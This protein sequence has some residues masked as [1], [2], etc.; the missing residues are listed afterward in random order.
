MN[1]LLPLQ[2]GIFCEMDE[3]ASGHLSGKLRCNERA[4]ASQVEA[5]V[6]GVIPGKSTE[7]FLQRQQSLLRF[8]GGI[9]VGGLATAACLF[10]N[11]C[12]AHLGLSLNAISL[13]MVAGYV[14]SAL[15][16]VL[17]WPLFP[18]PGT[19]VFSSSFMKSA[20]QLP[21]CTGTRTGLMREGFAVFETGPVQSSYCEQADTVRCTVQAQSLMQLP[22]LSSALDREK[23]LLFTSLGGD[24]EQ[25]PKGL[26]PSSARAM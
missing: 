17:S 5:G 12:R 7:E 6:K 21:S 1:A 20:L 10:D 24:Q 14:S 2:S 18:T 8:W 4:A 19:A 11:A 9:A 15:R 22:R 13:V 25:D 26:A 23:E 16:Q 3:I